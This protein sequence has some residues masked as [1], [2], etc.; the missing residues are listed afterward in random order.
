MCA[1]VPSGIMLETRDGQRE[2][3]Y[4]HTCAAACTRVCIHDMYMRISER[5]AVFS[6]AHG[7]RD[8]PTEHTKT[9]TG[10]SAL[11]ARGTCTQLTNHS[12]RARRKSV[13]MS[14]LGA[15]SR[16]RLGRGEG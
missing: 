8:V 1:L 6:T 13:P 11:P 14:L 15:E 3:T 7:L 16:R 5:K 12:R 2:H 10:G 9:A 4:T